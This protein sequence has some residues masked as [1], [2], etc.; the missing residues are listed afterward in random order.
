VVLFWGDDEFLLR[1]AALDLF[2]E[3]GVKPTE[4]DAS[5]WRGGETS[6][7][8]TPSLWG[9]KRALLV[10]QCQDLPEVG[11]KELAAYVAA[12]APEALL[13]LTLGSRGKQPPP[14]AKRVQTAGG[15]VRHIALTRQDL[16]KWVVD[17]GRTRGVKLTG[18]AA[19]TLVAAVGES[20]AAL[21]QAV[22]Q[23]AT[24]FAGASIGPSEIRSQFRGLGEQRVWDLCDQALSG[25]LSQAL[26]PCEG[27]SRHAKIR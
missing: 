11:A 2:D 3:R 22:E 26:S 10:S 24:A 4:V 5:D 14:L 17:R 23:L 13:V 15:L 19:S 6:D 7:L 16:T 8:A 27:C 12:P 9:E 18:P 21:D 1:M 25:R 20:T